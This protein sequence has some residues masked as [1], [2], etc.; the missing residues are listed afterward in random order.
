MELQERIVYLDIKVFATIN[1]SGV[2][3]GVRENTIANFILYEEKVGLKTS[4]CEFSGD[5]IVPSNEHN[6]L[7]MHEQNWGLCMFFRAESKLSISPKNG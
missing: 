3:E 4:D 1:D 7:V 6:F 2:G 5:N